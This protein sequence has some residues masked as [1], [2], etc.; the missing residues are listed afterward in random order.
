[1]NEVKC[2]NC[3]QA[4][5]FSQAA[6]ARTLRCFRCDHRFTVEQGGAGEWRTLDVVIS[7]DAAGPLNSSAPAT[8]VERLVDEGF[9]PFDALHPWAEILLVVWKWLAVIAAVGLVLAGLVLLLDAIAYQSQPSTRAYGNS[10]AWNGLICLFAAPLEFIVSFGL[11][12]L[13]R[14]ALN[15]DSTLLD[16]RDKQS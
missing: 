12:E 1:M 16:I 11:I 14:A 8:A 2:P 13:A 10:L 5:K 4:V 9:H 6:A 3:S 15:I 7:T